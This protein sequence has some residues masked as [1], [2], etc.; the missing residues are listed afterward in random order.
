[1]KINSLETIEYILRL[2]VFMTFLGHGM[3]AYLGNAGWLGYLLTAGFSLENAND[4]LPLIGVL[5]MVVALIILLKPLK[6]VVLWAVIWAFSTALIRP[7]SGESVWA[8]VERGANWG[9]PLALFLLLQ[10]QK[11]TISE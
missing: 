9:A 8:F 11:N 5:D 7:L 3:V 1:M 4:V 6:Y 10:Y 2:V